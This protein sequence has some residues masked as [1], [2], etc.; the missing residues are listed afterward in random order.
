MD[1]KAFSRN[2][3]QEKPGEVASFTQETEVEIPGPPIDLTVKDVTE[4]SFTIAWSPP[5][6]R[7]QCV[8]TYEYGLSQLHDAKVEVRLGVLEAYVGS[9][10]CGTSYSFTVRAVDSLGQKSPSTK[11][12]GIETLPCF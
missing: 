7:P 2:W 3:G 1:I 5:T 4:D 12:E 9:L 10:Q 6:E 11:M 8:D